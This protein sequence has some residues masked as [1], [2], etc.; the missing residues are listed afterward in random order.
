LGADELWT[1]RLKNVSN[2]ELLCTLAYTDPGGKGQLHSYV[3]LPSAALHGFAS[4]T[5]R[6]RPETLS[7]RD[8]ETGWTFALSFPEGQHDLNATVQGGGAAGL[9]ALGPL[10]YAPPA[11]S[12]SDDIWT[13]T[14]KNLT[15]ELLEGSLAREAFPGLD[16]EH[17]TG[18]GQADNRFVLA[19]DT[20]LSITQLGRPETVSVRGGGRG[21]TSALSFPEGQHE[22]TF[23]VM[24]GPAFGYVIGPSRPL[25]WAASIATEPA[26]SS[27]V[28]PLTPSEGAYASV[29]D[30]T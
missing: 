28:R 4:V 17:S 27:T 24:G 14:L 18:Q 15:N 26:G 12:G 21:A 10:S 25:T 6:G 16:D 5:Q 2:V 23:A 1:V 13:V 7:V 22:L 30:G 3:V 20:V 8:R 29:Q 11:V 19:P 9:Y